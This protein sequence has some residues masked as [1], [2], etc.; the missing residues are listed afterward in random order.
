MKQLN[1]VIRMLDGILEDVDKKFEP[2]FRELKDQL[3]QIEKKVDE[4]LRK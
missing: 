1:E 4:L 2:R 3:D